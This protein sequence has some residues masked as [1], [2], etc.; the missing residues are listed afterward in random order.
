VRDA[1]KHA[2]VI[3][4]VKEGA[5]TL[6]LVNQ[7]VIESPILGVEGNREFLAFYQRAAD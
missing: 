5:A 2:R 6:G 1:E 7:G 4:E 3:D